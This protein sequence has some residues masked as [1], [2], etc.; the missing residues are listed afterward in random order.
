MGFGGRLFLRVIEVPPLIRGNQKARPLGELSPRSEAEDLATERGMFFREN[1]LSVGFAATSP[2]GRGFGE[3][4]RLCLR[5]TDWVRVA[6]GHGS[7]RT[8]TPTRVKYNAF[9][10]DKPIGFGG[11]LFLRVVEAPTPTES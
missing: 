10:I 9:V 6:G 3:A 5:Q 11:R 4:I 2:M 7:S 8:S 1:A